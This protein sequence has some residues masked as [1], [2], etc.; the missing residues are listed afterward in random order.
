MSKSVKKVT[1]VLDFTV[2]EEAEGKRLDTFL[3]N[4]YGEFSRSY[5]QKL[6]EEG[7]VFIDELEVRKPSKKVKAGQKITFFVPSG[8]PLEIM[9]EDIPFD[10]VYEDQHIIVLIKPCGL[11]VHPSPG[12]SRGTLVNALL[13]RVKELSGIGGVERPGIVHRLDKNT[14]GLMVVAKTDKAHV[15]LAKQFQN[16]TVL[17]L[18][19][20]LVSGLIKEESGVIEK[21]IA[22]HIID[23]KRFSVSQDG[24]PAKTEYRLIKR[25]EKHKV[26]LL[27]VRIYTG[28]TH[29]I[30]VHLSSL[31]YPILGDTTYGFKSS[32]V[33]PKIRELMGDCHMLVSYRL[34]FSHPISGKWMDFKIQDPEPFRSV[35]A[36]LEDT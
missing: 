22:R 11:V 28:R 8:E 7:F 30:R 4:A 3:T 25:F 6:I 12:H 29:Q 36:F 23:R 15:S 35:L 13:Y 2:G 33:D 19:H 5:I 1:E 14:A 32:S 21:P 18:Y 27:D 16:R 9:P 10:T 31:G 34:A 17:K 24:K 20:A 26:S